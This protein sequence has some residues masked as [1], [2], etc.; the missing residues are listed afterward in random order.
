MGRSSCSFCGFVF[1]DSRDDIPMTESSAHL[2]EGKAQKIAMMKKYNLTR[3]D[4]K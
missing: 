3:E 4:L 1:Y 2:C